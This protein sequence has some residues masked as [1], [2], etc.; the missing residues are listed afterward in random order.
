MCIYTRPRIEGLMI[1]N[2]SLS[3]YIITLNQINTSCRR[4]LFI[5]RLLRVSEHVNFVNCYVNE[6]YEQLCLVY[7]RW[8]RHYAGSGSHHLYDNFITDDTGDCHYNRI[9]CIQCWQKIVNMLAFPFQPMFHG[10]LVHH[11]WWYTAYL[12]KSAH[13]FHSSV[14]CGYTKLYHVG[15][16]YFV[17][18]W[19][20]NRDA[21]LQNIDKLISPI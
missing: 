7:P 20:G 19:V 10:L 14:F 18:D 16:D 15:K 6:I 3:E 21:T 4:L 8:S 11:Q 2:S 1:C 17:D 13:G 9:Q 12:K 5:H